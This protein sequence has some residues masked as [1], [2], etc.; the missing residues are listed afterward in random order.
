MQSQKT[1]KAMRH[2]L[3][4]LLYKCGTST[5]NEVLSRYLKH[6]CHQR[7]SLGL[8]SSS[9][10][11]RTNAYNKLL[12]Y[13]ST[14]FLH[15]HLKL[16]IMSYCHGYCIWAE[17]SWSWKKSRTNPLEQRVWLDLPATIRKKLP[18]RFHAYATDQASRNSPYA[19]VE[20][21]VERTRDFAILAVKFMKRQLNESANGNI[22]ILAENV[23]NMIKIE[24]LAS[25]QN[26]RQWLQ[27]PIS[28]DTI[29][30]RLQ[31]IQTMTKERRQSIG[32][33]DQ[34]FDKMCRRIATYDIDQQ[35]TPPS[36]SQSSSQQPYRQSQSALQIN[37]I[38]F[39]NDSSN[40]D[41]NSHQDRKN[42]RE[43]IRT[44][45]GTSGRMV[46]RVANRPR[47]NTASNQD[48]TVATATTC[49]GRNG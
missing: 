24:R 28:L 15:F 22:W 23:R 30:I 34:D 46:E 38:G 25:F 21:L 26:L 18:Q 6:Q 48:K 42:G 20:N 29:K 43:A 19:L 37:A 13:T 32:S 39:D 36:T 47:L 16:T 5:N 9:R 8:R 27:E 31:E 33:F 41:D 44:Q 45:T 7:K 12:L 10:S 4:A 40:D 17:R 14:T 3:C 35:S 2:S 49:P 1:G 11:I